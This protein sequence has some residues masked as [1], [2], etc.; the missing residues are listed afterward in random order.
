MTAPPFP[1]RAALLA[2]LDAQGYDT[3][4]H[5]HPAVF[6][7]AESSE[8]HRS[9]RGGHTKNLFLR[10][11]K[12]N[13]FLVTAEQDTEVDLKRLH[14]VI[15]GASRFSFG[16]P[17]Q[18]LEWLG[19]TPGSV[20]ALAIANDVEGRVR[21][22]LDERLLRHDHVNCHPLVNDATTTIRRDDLVAFATAHGHEPLVADLTG[23]SLEA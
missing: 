19:V 2:H 14:K 21:F 13:H 12:G 9:M 18:L 17:E 11:R 20:T 15:G 23:A 8:L 22:V 10:D 4:T 3:E 7:V 1:D 16:K 6:T 5:D